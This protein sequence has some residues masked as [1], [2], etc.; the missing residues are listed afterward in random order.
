[1]RVKQIQKQYQIDLGDMKDT[2][3]EYYG[4]TY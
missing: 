3:L 1:M 4:V 2:A